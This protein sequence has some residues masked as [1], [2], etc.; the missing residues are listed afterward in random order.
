METAMKKLSIILIM[1]A[2]SFNMFA[3]DSLNSKSIF[4]WGVFADYN[5]NSYSA[6]FKSLPG[7]YN[8]SPG[9]DGGSGSGYSVGGL[10]EYFLDPQ[11]RLSLR[12]G[13]S[14]L[15][16]ELTKDEFIGN[17]LNKG[18]ASYI[19]KINVEHSLKTNLKLVGFEPGISYEFYKRTL[20]YFGLKFG[21][22][23]TS[24]FS[25]KESIKSPSNAVY[26]PSNTTQRNIYNNQDI[27]DKNSL[28]VFAALGLSYEFPISKSYKLC[29]EIRYEI[30]FNNI[31]SV[32]WKVSALN[33]GL[34]FKAPFS[35]P[36]KKTYDS[37]YISRDTS[38]IFIKGATQMRVTLQDRKEVKA[39]V[40]Y[41]DYI[42][43]RTTVTE[44]YQREIPQ[45]PTKPEVFLAVKGISSEG[46][47]VKM[48]E[49]VIEEIEAE[50]SFPLLTQIFFKTNDADLQNTSLIKLTPA[51]SAYFQEES[52]PWDAIEIYKNVLNIVGYRMRKL[53]DAKLNII[54]C[55]NNMGLETDN[56]ILSTARAESVKKYLKEVW[57][58]APERLTST[59]RNLPENHANNQRAQ[60]V[61]ENRR[62]EL[63]SADPDLLAPVKLSE[64][65]RIANP[66]I[67][68]IIPKVKSES[69]FTWNI[70][71]TQGSAKLRTYKGSGAPDSIDWKVEINPTPMLEAP[72][73]A[74]LTAK[75]EYF[76]SAATSQD[77]TINQRTIKKKK[78]EMIN[79]KRIDRF[80]LILFDYDKSNITDKHKEIIESIKARITPNSKVKIYGYTDMTGD[81]AYNKR[82]ASERAKKV[83]A[84]LE[85]NENQAEILSVGNALELFDNSTPEGRSYSRTVKV[86]IETPIEE[87]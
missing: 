86:V 1:L 29:P 46:S 15:D 58:I 20:A 26:Y 73:K 21:M 32:D 52:L 50:E 80:S 48:P 59:A 23:T 66:P 63:S 82:L 38:E 72:V 27:S 13:Y 8:C 75:D 44:K 19:T 35:Q 5:Y 79:D 12:L 62:V 3:S 4:Y 74:E 9:F 28:L 61:E 42:V 83:F 16:G 57:G 40:E 43:N 65:H 47:E 24:Q 18:V 71:V 33:I 36:G 7:Y 11:F 6:D 78:I 45:L 22:A 37:L 34:A 56:V 69:N 77:I 49:L 54:G 70:D 68:R 2:A 85:L 30:P 25:Q 51:A 87:E 53:K 41:E 55:N 60:G 64:L 81:K 17:G 14:S 84:L 39:T 76:Q 10:L 31:S 67:V